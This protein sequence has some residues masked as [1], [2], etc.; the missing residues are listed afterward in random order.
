MR[1]ENT[2]SREM[3][4]M[5]HAIV[6]N[7]CSFFKQPQIMRHS[8]GPKLICPPDFVQSTQVE[9]DGDKQCRL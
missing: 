8:H 1:V 3:A 4:G 9:L 7:I 5:A 2:P 6:F